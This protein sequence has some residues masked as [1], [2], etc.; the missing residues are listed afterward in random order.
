MADLSVCNQMQWHL[1]LP[2]QPHGIPFRSSASTCRDFLPGSLV[3]SSLSGFSH[4]SHVVSRGNPNFEV[5]YSFLLSLLTIRKRTPTNQHHFYQL[6]EP[7][8]FV[9]IWTCTMAAILFLRGG[10]VGY[11]RDASVVYDF[12][13]SLMHP[14][15][16][17]V[18]FC[19][20]SHYS[21][22]LTGSIL[23]LSSLHF[24]LP[25]RV[26]M[27]SVP[28]TLERTGSTALL[29]G[30]C[31]VLNSSA[32]V[33]LLFCPS[34]SLIYGDLYLGLPPGLQHF[35]VNIQLSFWSAFLIGL[36]M[37]L[38]ISS[39]HHCWLRSIFIA[40]ALCLVVYYILQIFAAQ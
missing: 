35:P 29:G 15:F 17:L 21:H 2:W 8:T 5:H 33:F 36:S 19:F 13:S 37:G 12:P 9:P 34:S 38:I 25:H 4:Y 20:E 1:T 11:W 23:K 10:D 18:W 14:Q 28:A 6:E 22:G 3:I 30:S 39:H 16:L 24:I 31:S 27:F 40:L 7:N 26:N 32:F